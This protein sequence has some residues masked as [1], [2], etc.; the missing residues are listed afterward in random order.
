MSSKKIVS[1]KGYSGC[2]LQ[3]DE[4][5]GKWFVTKYSGGVEYNPRLKLQ[6]EKQRRFEET[7][8]I[9]T[10]TVM[11]E[12]IKDGVYFYTME[13]IK[14]QTFA[15][16]CKTE[17]IDSILGKLEIVLKWIKSLREKHCCPGQSAIEAF[18]RKIVSISESIGKNDY[19]Q[20]YLDYLISFDWSSVPASSCHGDLTLE[21]MILSR[22]NIY[23]I[24]FL[25]SFYE[26]WMFDVAKLMQDLEL[27]WSY[28]Y[29]KLSQEVNLKMQIA[30]RCVDEK[31]KSLT[32]NE[33]HTI[34]A[35]LAMNI[36]RIYPYCNDNTT[37]QWIYNALNVV[38]TKRLLI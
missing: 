8:A 7:E 34:Y 19:L 28:R 16:Y 22:E 4:K 35:I 2:P 17:P 12:G 1:L 23:L 29:E 30:C 37:R 10:P 14:G 6:C 38:Y 31:M 20:P 32:D 27:G 25:D 13:Y 21:N 9:K 24:D 11:D 18:N 36:L 3:L 5:D 15:D 33:V 26:S